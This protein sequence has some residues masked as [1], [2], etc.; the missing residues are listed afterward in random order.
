MIVVFPNLF[1][2][3]DNQVLVFIHVNVWRSVQHVQKNIKSGDFDSERALIKTKDTL[4][5]KKR[6]GG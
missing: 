6:K 2:H 1:L 5:L 4:F 3:Y